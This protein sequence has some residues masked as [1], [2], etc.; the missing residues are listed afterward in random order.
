MTFNLHRI[1]PFQGLEFT[2]IELFYNN[3]IPSGL[4]EE[5]NEI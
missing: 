5:W 1:S 4:L 2:H 3:N